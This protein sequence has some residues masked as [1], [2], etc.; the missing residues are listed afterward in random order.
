MCLGLGRS[1]GQSHHHDGMGQEMAIGQA[2][3]GLLQPSG[4]GL[5]IAELL[6]R[7]KE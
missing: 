3:P 1:V 5:D 4:C 2:G 7:E 6:R